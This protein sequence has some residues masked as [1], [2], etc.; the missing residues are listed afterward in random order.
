MNSIT[1]FG[2]TYK[3]IGTDAAIEILVNT[4]IQKLK[5]IWGNPE[6]F[7]EYLEYLSTCVAAEGKPET[8]PAG[9]GIYGLTA[10]I[11]DINYLIWTSDGC[12]HRDGEY[13]TYW[14]YLGA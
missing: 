11:D 3:E 14:E 5:K 12:T 6:H 10:Y 8:V 13:G 2:K 7:E 9:D 1:E 4:P